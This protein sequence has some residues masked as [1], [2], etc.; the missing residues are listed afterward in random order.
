M[1]EKY[2]KRIFDVLFSMFGIIILSPIILVVALL[3]FIDSGYPIIYKQKRVTMHKKIFLIFKFR[4]MKIGAEKE[5]VLTVG[6]DKRI[7]KMGKIL[8][9]TKLDELPQLFN[10][11][12]GDMS[13]VGPRPETPKYVA[14]YQK[15]WQ[16]IFKIRAG[17]TDYASIHFSDESEHFNVN[18]PE[19]DYLERILPAKIILKKKYIQNISFLND[20][21]I[22]LMT[23]LKIFK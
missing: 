15:N 20:I 7:T 17:I 18:D 6:N 12:F 11:L 19:K 1:Y 4:T 9:K 22:I 3:I 10:V 8:R 14:H 2:F 5:G 13:F 21:K 16:D 23:I